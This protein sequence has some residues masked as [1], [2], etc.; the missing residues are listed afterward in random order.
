[1]GWAPLRL[2]MLRTILYFGK[3]RQRVSL[4]KGHL[5]EFVVDLLLEAQDVLVVLL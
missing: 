2:E 4:P 1:M 5:P 3:A